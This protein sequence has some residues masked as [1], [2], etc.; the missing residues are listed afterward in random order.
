M[1]HGEMT[2]WGWMVL[3]PENLMMNPYVDIGAF[4][5]IHAGAGVELWTEV[6]IGSHCAIYSVST[7]DNK[8]APVIISAHAK[9]G[10][11]CTIMPG[12]TIGADSVIGAHSFVN[13][14]ISAGFLAYGVPARTV[15]CL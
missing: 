15:R 1:K 13:K 3:Y 6:E 8:A 10:S 11:H 2:K 9:I 7:I 12:V 4:T 14:S 5:L